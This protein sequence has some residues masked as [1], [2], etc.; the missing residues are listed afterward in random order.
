MEVVAAELVRI[1]EDVSNRLKMVSE[2]EAVIRPSSEERSKKEVVG[3]LIDSA[4]N[5]HQRFVRAQY[6]EQRVFPPYEQEEW[7]RV[8]K[9]NDASWEHLIDLWRL[10]NLHI[11]YIIRRIPSDKLSTTCRIGSN[12]PVTLGYLVEDYVSHMKRHFKQLGL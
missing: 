1:L 12:D 11:S 5:N 9:Y 2:H 8:Q 4:A 3:H 7:V 10:Y 6:Q